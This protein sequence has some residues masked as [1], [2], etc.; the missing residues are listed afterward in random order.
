LTP[1]NPGPISRFLIAVAPALLV[2]ACATAPPPSN[3]ADVDAAAA[4]RANREWEETTR[5][6]ADALMAEAQL[7]QSEGRFDEALAKT[8]EALC[9]VVNTPPGYQPQI[10]YIEYLAE[11]I[12]EADALE[13]S[14]LP[15]EDGLESTEEYVSLPPLDIFFDEDVGAVEADVEESLLPESDIPLV[16]NPT[17]ERFLEAMSSPGEYRN[18]IAAGLE[19]AGTYLPMIRARLERARLPLDLG[20]LPLIESAY[21]NRAYSRA[22]AMGMWQFIASTGRH[23]DLEVGSLIDERR[24]PVLSTD[25]AIAYLDDLYDQ[26]GDWYLALA[27]YNSGSG[28]VRRAIR[29]SGST[30]FWVLKRFLPRET[31]NYVPAFIAS[32]IVAHNPQ[33][34]GFEAPVDRPWVYDSIEV[35]D[36]LD[37]Q[38]MADNSGIPLGELRELN[39]AIRRDL[40]PARGTTVLRLPPGTA[41][42]AEAVL[43]STA[44]EKWAPRMLHTVR[45]GDSLYAIARKYGSS[46]SDI[47]Q[48]NGLR[49]SLIRPGQT[50]VVPRYGA[51]AN[52]S[53][54]ASRSTETDGTYVVRRNDTLW[55]IAR[56]FSISIDSLCSANGL[57]RNDIIRPGQ[58]LKIP[59]GS[60]DTAYQPS[61]ASGT[62]SVSSHTVRRGDTLSD[63]ANRYGVTV[64]AIK[65]ANGLSSSRI[66]PGKVLRIPAGV[67]SPQTQKTA[68]GG[69]TYRVRKGDTLY[70]IAQRFGVSISALRRANGL[71]SS[72]IYPGDVLQIPRSQAKG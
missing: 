15:F 5:N 32:V 44:R 16:I 13:S 22:R 58:R 56:G 10:V 70:D 64:N 46:V 3:D 23:Y 51:V 34:Y 50:L 21:S 36:A 55:E 11:L 20:Y 29:R 18:R 61:I 28:N 72:R 49:G 68:S 2:V 26:F 47:R 62:G 59:D 7:L 8:D 1:K 65:A 30:D 43:E 9:E 53:A 69:T 31:R 25:A 27:A 6:R 40:T 52:R 37:L 41:P 71:S 48:A 54:R 17:V 14:S 45:S 42:R 66:Y 38:F 24:D 67:G 39:P 60:R 57:S 19:R 35:P 63:I 4:A 33:R 12:D